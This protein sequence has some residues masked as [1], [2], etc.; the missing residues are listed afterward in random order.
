VLR[1]LEGSTVDL[2]NDQ[3][4]F[5][6]GAAVRPGELVRLGISHPCTA[7]DKWRV[8]PIVDDSYRVVD[9]IDTYF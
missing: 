7:F 4:A 1:P 3:H 2:L 5:L 6:R 8:V 9:V